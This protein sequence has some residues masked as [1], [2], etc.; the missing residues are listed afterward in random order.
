MTTESPNKFS[1]SVVIPV[2]NEAENI[3][4]TLEKLRDNVPVSHE[5]LVVY[6]RD[7]D[8]TVPIVRQLASRFPHVK[9]VKNRVCRGPSG[10]LRTGFAEARAARVLVTMADQSDDLS[11]VGQLL[12][13]VPARADIACPSRYCPGGAQLMGPSL[14]V[15]IPRFAGWLMR[16]LTGLPTYDPTNSF[17]LYSAEVL[18]GLR[19]TSTVSFSVT[20]EVIAKA[21]GLGYR[22]AEIPTT[23]RDRRAGQ[24]NFPLARSVLTY[25]PW[26]LVMLLNNRLFRL[27]RAWLRRWFGAQ[28]DGS[29]ASLTDPK[30]KVST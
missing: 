1:L 2:Y 26:F 19:L 6:D 8:T 28:A 16:L 25:L 20:L 12:E 5:V 9:L 7:D 30:V 29:P 27:P 3:V 23:W 4:P 18:N 13:L 24:S 15:F 10:A 11:Q 22:I 14:K 17:K 21:H